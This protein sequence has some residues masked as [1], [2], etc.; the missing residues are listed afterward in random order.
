MPTRL[1]YGL[2]FIKPGAVA[3]AY[4]FTA[5]DQT[6]DV[7]L[8]TVFF[9]AASALTITNFDG[10]ER[11]KII[12]VFSN[13]DG[14]TT[15]QNSAGGINTFSVIGSNSAGFVKYSSGTSTYLMTNNESLMYL[16]NGTD[17]SQISP[18]L[19]LP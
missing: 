1:P 10:G 13:S 5:G 17:W 15:I 18:S 4:T 16:H 8:G 3:G 12:I 6:P 14:A 9:T 7:S 11:G 19:R 2:V